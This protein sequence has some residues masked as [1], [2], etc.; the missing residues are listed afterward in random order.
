MLVIMH[1][2]ARRFKLMQTFSLKTEGAVANFCGQLISKDVFDFTVTMDSRGFA[3]EIDSGIDYRLYRRDAERLIEYLEEHVRVL[4]CEER[5]E[6]PVFVPQELCFQIRA[7]DGVIE[8]SMDGYFT[9]NFMLR[10]D[11]GYWGFEGVWDLIDLNEF[12][13]KLRSIFPS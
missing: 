10:F 6:S 12:V 7:F 5:V 13:A 1:G 2:K 4:R 11:V 8:S 9:I 3:K